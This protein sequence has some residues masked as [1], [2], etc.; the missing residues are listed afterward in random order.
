[1]PASPFTANTADAEAIHYS[2]SLQQNDMKQ[3]S[4]MTFVSRPIV[5]LHDTSVAEKCKLRSLPEMRK[6]V[7]SVTAYPRGTCSLGMF[8]GAA[9]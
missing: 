8:E 1:M 3:L 4:K 9:R 7:D 5:T 2:C 6:S